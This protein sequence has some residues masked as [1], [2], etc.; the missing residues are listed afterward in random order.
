MET[1]VSINACSALA[2]C[3]AAN[4][5]SIIALQKEKRAAVLE[6]FGS[7][8]SGPSAGAV[9][10]YS[11][12]SLRLVGRSF[13]SGNTPETVPSWMETVSFQYV[14]LGIRGSSHL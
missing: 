5:V 11:I 7:R 13:C 10:L 9:L 4:K 1:V 8:I 12:T 2:C 14:P 3:A 6:P